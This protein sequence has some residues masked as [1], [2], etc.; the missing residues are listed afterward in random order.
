MFWVVTSPTI[1]QSR[2]IQ[3][4]ERCY[5]AIHEARTRQIAM[6]LT[7]Y[8]V[9]SVCVGALASF[10]VSALAAWDASYPSGAGHG[11]LLRFR[12]DERPVILQLWTLVT[13]TSWGAGS[14]FWGHDRLPERTQ[15]VFRCENNALVW[16]LG[17]GL[18]DSI[19]VVECAFRG[20]ES[21]DVAKDWS[22]RC[23]N[24]GAFL[25]RDEDVD[26]PA[27]ALVVPRPHWFTRHLGSEVTGEVPIH[28][29]LVSVWY[30]TT[31]LDES[32]LVAQYTQTPD[33]I[34]KTVFME[35]QCIDE[36][37]AYGWPLRTF[38]VHGV[39]RL[40]YFSSTELATGS[41]MEEW[42]DGIGALPRPALIAGLEH[43]PATGIAWRPIWLLLALNSVI[44]GVPLTIAAVAARRVMWR[45]LTTCWTSPDLVDAKN[46]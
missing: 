41:S 7:R 35:E 11:E 31:A 32:R 40:R 33:E 16:R 17:R 45:Q 4:G 43:L 3:S 12:D 26:D 24:G 15:G 22:W 21:S 19:I 36:T 39:L 2:G 28:A 6:K 13:P 25:S 23:L 34:A 38:V 30:E 42:S 37:R 8:I 9:T 10:G 27:R 5:R 1:S 29:P 20:D 44:L 18:F 46:R 14:V